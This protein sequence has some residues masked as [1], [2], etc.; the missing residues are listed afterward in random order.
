MLKGEEKRREQERRLKK[1]ERQCS[2]NHV[3]PALDKI[4]M[5]MMPLCPLTLR[6]R[7][8]VY[9]ISASQR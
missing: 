6:L 5:P 2:L 7:N 9:H 4:G 3:A 8:K 1:R